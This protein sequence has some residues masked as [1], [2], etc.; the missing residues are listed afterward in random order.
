VNIRNRIGG[1]PMD[2]GYMAD[3]L[4]IALCTYFESHLD[5]PE[6]DPIDDEIGWGEWVIEMSDKAL[7][8]IAEEALS[9][10]EKD[11]A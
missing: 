1:V 2:E 11:N 6:N 4:A 10:M 5:R 7:D 3:N 9:E 8:R